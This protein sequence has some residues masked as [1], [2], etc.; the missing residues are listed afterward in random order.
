MVAEASE[1]LEADR[2]RWTRLYV[3]AAGAATL[4]MLGLAWWAGQGTPKLEARRLAYIELRM[5]R[6]ARDRLVDHLTGMEYRIRQLAAVPQIISPEDKIPDPRFLDRTF[7]QIDLDGVVVRRY[8]PD[9]KLLLDLPIGTQRLPK[10]AEP[11]LREMLDWAKDPKHQDA[12]LFDLGEALGTGESPARDLVRFVVSVWKKENGTEPAPDGVL[13]VWVPSA[14]LL[15]SFLAPTHLLPESYSFA[16]YWSGTAGSP[17]GDPV[18]LWHSSEPHWVRAKGG[19]AG[20]FLA[21]LRQHGS[22]LAEG[23]EDFEILD[24]PRRDGESRREIVAVVPVVFGAKR[25]LVGLSTPFEVA[26]EYSTGLR[27]LLVLL[28]LLTLAVL[29]VGVLILLYE[30]SRFLAD[31]SRQRELQIHAM[32]HDYGELFAENPTAMIVCDEEGTLLDCNHSAERMIGLSRVEAKGTRLSDLFEA[33]SIEPLWEGLAGRGHLHFRDAQIVRKSDQ[34]VMLVE[35]WGR[36]IGGRFVLMAHNVEQQ[37]DL[38]QQVARLKRMDS[39]GSLA[40][41]LAHD[42]NNLLGQVQ[43]LVSHLRTEISFDSPLAEDVA[44]IEKKVDD[45]SQLVSNLLASREHVA[46]REPVWLEPVLR[47]FAA[48]LPKVAPE[49]VQIVADI[50]EDLPAVWVTPHA[51]RRVLDNLCINAIDAMPYGGKL[52]LRAFA[53]RIDSSSATAQLP[54]GGYAVLEVTDTGAGM[55]REVLDAI[56]EP[57]FTT[58]PHTRGRGMGLGLWT[59]YRIVRRV[60]GSIE[61]HSRPG[62]GTQFS[63]YLPTSPPM[64]SDGSIPALGALARNASYSPGGAEGPAPASRPVSEGRR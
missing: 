34:Q 49:R 55:S 17:G 41:A 7:G 2:R 32:Q 20:A 33:E 29:A 39:I 12:T 13:C 45:A 40:S 1:R 14:T 18:L 5:L 35:V 15:S 62:K 64:Q 16:L 61:V 37:R 58:K 56:F 57:F 50:R 59:V 31:A 9:G 46:S 23:G 54:A 52:T 25:W 48:N 63:V 3:A 36:T 30:R 8:G 47:E 24:I 22:A 51:L 53:R 19:D 44:A 10:V 27:N 28:A 38:E 60:G 26:V 21:A 4:I 42:F 43:I 11:E 6:Q